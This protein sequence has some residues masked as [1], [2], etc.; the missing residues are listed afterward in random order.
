M[1]YFLGR[2]SLKRNEVKL[3]S[4][5]EKTPS[6]NFNLKLF[7]FIMAYEVLG[8]KNLLKSNSNCAIELFGC[9]LKDP[10][11]EWEP[12]IRLIDPSLECPPGCRVSV[13]ADTGNFYVSYRFSGYYCGRPFS[14]LSWKVGVRRRRK[15]AGKKLPNRWLFKVYFG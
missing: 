11:V 13:G 4:L 3:S 15:E 12:L 1:V 5:V 10:Y 2:F 8:C 9:S 7:W 14:S 6:Y